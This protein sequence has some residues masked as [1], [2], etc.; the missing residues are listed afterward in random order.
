MPPT[1]PVS[2]Y[3]IVTQA[4]N[5]KANYRYMLTSG[6]GAANTVSQTPG[7]SSMGPFTTLAQAQAAVAAL[8][9]AVNVNAPGAVPGVTPP[10][11]PGVTPT[12]LVPK[13]TTPAAAAAQK[14][15]ATIAQP[16]FDKRMTSIHNPLTNGGGGFERGFMVWDTT[17]TGTAGY[18][19][20]SPPYINFLFNPSTVQASYS[21]SD[22]TAQAALIF[23]VGGGSGVPWVGLQQSMNFTIMFD[24]SYELN[25]DIGLT[26]PTNPI[27]SM[28]CEV[29]V[30][31]MKQ[32]TG[33]FS[34]ASGD[35][36]YY[37]SAAATATSGGGTGGG[38]SGGAS[39]G[40]ST[41]TTTSGTGLPTALGTNQPAPTQATGLTN[42]PQQGIMLMMPS[43]CYFGFGGEGGTS[44]YYGYVQNWDVQYTH[45]TS[46]MIPIRC[47]IDVTYTLL[48]QAGNSAAELTNA[49]VKA[50]SANQIQQ[51]LTPTIPTPGG[52]GLFG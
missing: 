13:T 43:Y 11:Q 27:A 46:T 47:V 23:G 4:A 39:G 26:D 51:A 21:M 49:A 22:S 18:S 29:D 17:F 25:S 16:P 37:T 31:M 52:L 45:Y 20:A 2:Y 38:A 36:G 32:F 41:S 19:A 8:T 14:T 15:V 35:S 48:P 30:R 40:T 44:Q 6:Q 24:R 42:G 12:A 1:P 7:A 5:S 28:G 9:P 3:V 34:T 10:A 33:M 50:L